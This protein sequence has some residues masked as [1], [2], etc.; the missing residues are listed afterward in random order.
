MFAGLPKVVSLLAHC[1][2][3]RPNITALLGRGLMEVP[4]YLDLARTVRPLAV[5]PHPPLLCH[6]A[7]RQGPVLSSGK[8]TRS[9]K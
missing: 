5:D 8:E 6:C 2:G 4:A 7:G 1:I 9:Y 3:R